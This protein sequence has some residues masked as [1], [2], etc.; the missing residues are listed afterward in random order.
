MT[1]SYE[2]GRE[3]RHWRKS[4]SR[5]VFLIVGILLEQDQH[6]ADTETTATPPLPPGD[7]PGSIR[8]KRPRHVPLAAGAA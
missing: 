8:G 1:G 6:T 7:R 5:P 4:P 2:V 3:F